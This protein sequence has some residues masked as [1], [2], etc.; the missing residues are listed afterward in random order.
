VALYI[1][2]ITGRIVKS[3]EDR[4][5]TN[6]PKALYRESRDNSINR[7]INIGFSIGSKYIPLSDVF[8]GRCDTLFTKVLLAI[9]SYLDIGSLVYFVYI[10]RCF[11]ELA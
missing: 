1:T 11:Y 7:N 2:K 6:S 10:Y 5:G 9:Y 8:K 3:R 4:E